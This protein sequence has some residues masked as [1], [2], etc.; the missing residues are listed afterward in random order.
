MSWMP[1]PVIA[2]KAA[3]RAGHSAATT[4]AARPPQS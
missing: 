4:Q 1:Y 3:T 2:T